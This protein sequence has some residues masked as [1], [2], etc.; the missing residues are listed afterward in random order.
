MNN[1][2]HAE[3]KR[4]LVV[5]RKE[6]I[7]GK[8]ESAVLMGYF[9]Q[10]F[11]IDDIEQRIARSFYPDGFSIWAKLC[12][13]G[14][15][16]GHVDVCNLKIKKFGIRA[17]NSFR[18]TVA[19][20]RTND[21]VSGM[22]KMKRRHACGHSGRHCLC[23]RPAFQSGNAFFQRFP[24]RIQSTGIVVA[25]CF[26]NLLEPE[27]RRLVNRRNDAVVS[28][29]LIDTGMDGFCLKTHSRIPF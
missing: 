16:V 13:D 15:E 22:E 11:D 19:V 4:M 12:A 1:N 8:S 20:V 3:F 26:S 23:A 7:V 17:Q 10:S 25:L 2:I 14:L 5:R 21:M 6:R 9:G 27:C 24:G 18:T 29:V 28:S